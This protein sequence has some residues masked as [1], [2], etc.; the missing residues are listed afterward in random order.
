MLLVRVEVEWRRAVSHVPVAGEGGGEVSTAIWPTAKST[1]RR[2]YTY[3]EED[4][5]VWLRSR[6]LDGAVEEVERGDH[7]VLGQTVDIYD[8]WRH[9]NEDEVV[10]STVDVQG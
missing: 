1:G 8:A 4:N 6:T 9:G 10:A 2:F 7:T 5:R 3:D